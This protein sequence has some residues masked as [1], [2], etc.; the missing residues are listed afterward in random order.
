[1]LARCATAAT[2]V[3]PQAVVSHA[4]AA[5]LFGIALRPTPDVACVTVP[6]G[7]VG[8]IAGVHLH[9][10]ALPTASVELRN[11]VRITNVERTVIDIGREHGLEAAVVAVDSALHLRLT[12]RRRLD[13]A[14]RSHRRW[15]G[16]RAARRAVEFADSRSE[17]ALESVSRLRLDGRLPAPEP[18]AL[19]FDEGSFV[20]RVDF[21][22]P[23]EGVVGEADGLV[24]YDGESDTL[25]TEKARQERLER[26]GLT[27]VRWGFKD[28]AS[29]EALVTRISGGLG[30]GRHHTAPR[31]WTWMPRAR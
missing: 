3:N 13:I 14:L 10:A 25:Q 21:L 2:L 16:V 29:M 24:K 22:W 7:F 28:L 18:Q 15:P 9:R 30:R 1:M 23:D 12:S 5:V 27:V 31:T 19:I 4:S 26:S 6:S 20:G 11:G 8:D 17:S